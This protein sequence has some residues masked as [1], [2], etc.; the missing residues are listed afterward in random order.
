MQEQTSFC[1]KHLLSKTD[2]N[3]H[4]TKLI[5]PVKKKCHSRPKLSSLLEDVATAH[6]TASSSG[7]H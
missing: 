3:T 5:P 1:Q 4:V 6:P 2:T 7:S